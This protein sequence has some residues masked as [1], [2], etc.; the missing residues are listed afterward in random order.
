M[1]TG[2]S[3]LVIDIETAGLD[4][5]DIEVQK[6]LIEKNI[7]PALHPFFSKVI[8]IGLK[9]PREDPV[10]LH[11]DDEAKLLREF[12]GHIRASPLAMIVTFNGYGFDMPFLNA[13]SVMN[14]I[15]PEESINL[16]KWRMGHS[17]HF[18]IMQAL[19]QTGN[20]AWVSLDITARV[21]GVPV[22]EDQTSGAEMG[23][24]YKAGNW[25][26][27]VKHNTYDVEITEAIYLKIKDVF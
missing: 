20:F 4:P 19:S 13:R 17:N 1:T 2:E 7:V 26:E 21:L 6:Y 22:P 10:I 23:D 12:W 3:Y 27:I 24:L 16:N 25:D 15:S 8:A 11:G 9:K 14:G 18:D 5:S